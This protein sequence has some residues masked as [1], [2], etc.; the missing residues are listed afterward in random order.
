M[1]TMP[2]AFKGGNSPHQTFSQ[3]SFSPHT[4]SELPDHHQSWQIYTPSVQ[5]TELHGE[6][7]KGD[8][9]HHN[10]A[11]IVVNAGSIG[12]AGGTDIRAENVGDNGGNNDGRKDDHG[13]GGSGTADEAYRASHNSAVSSITSITASRDSATGLEE[14]RKRRERIETER[15]RLQRLQQLD[16]EEDALRRREE[17][18]KASP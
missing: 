11:G 3:G 16:E 4:L 8:R 15:Q 13:S 10:T 12:N 7:A 1:G 14:L 18:L 6:S 2:P 17:E 9:G 5:P